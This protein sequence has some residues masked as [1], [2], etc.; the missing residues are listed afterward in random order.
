MRM[1]L[2]LAQQKAQ[3]EQAERVAAAQR[4]QDAAAERNQ[5][6]EAQRRQAALERQRQAR[7]ALWQQAWAAQAR[8][9]DDTRR[10]AQDLA[11]QGI[12]Y[13]KPRKGGGLLGKVGRNITSAAGILKKA[14]RGVELVASGRVS[15]GVSK[16]GSAVHDVYRRV[17]SETKAGAKALDKLHHEV[18]VA[19]LK[20]FTKTHLFFLP[21]KTQDQLV[22]DAQR[23]S[24]KA[25]LEFRRQEPLI[26]EI[27]LF[28]ATVVV[29]VL[30]YGGGFALLPIVSVVGKAANEAINRAK[31]KSAAIDAIRDMRARIDQ[32]FVAEGLPPPAWGKVNANDAIGDMRSVLRAAGTAALSLIPV[33]GEALSAVA[34]SLSD[35]ASQADAER[36]ALRQF[37]GELNA[38]NA[39]LV[40]HGQPPMDPVPPGRS[41][42][43][44]LL[45]RFGVGA[46]ASLAGVI[47]GMGAASALG[48]L[49]SG[50]DLGR[51]LAAAGTKVVGSAA[52]AGAELGLAKALIGPQGPPVSAAMAAPPAEPVAAGPTAGAPPVP[53]PP[54]RAAMA[55][56]AILEPVPA[57]LALAA[58]G[59][60]FGMAILGGVA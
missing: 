23:F 33:V 54:P 8:A 9:L 46:G 2:F 3:A 6:A 15:K 43:E 41:T 55:P 20:L 51:T 53:A 19:S 17:E 35:V 45:R 31:A 37:R 38:V 5:E 18:A 32:A 60:A 30:T 42:A 50:S 4:E 16:V 29:G 57:I 1:A 56:P 40:A 36:L 14:A 47:A 49:A 7:A 24:H 44:D 59:A 52:A 25:T 12:W 27:V 22:K 28:A 13:K 26:R 21:K 34:R 48:G 10:L 58:V 11:S 39:D